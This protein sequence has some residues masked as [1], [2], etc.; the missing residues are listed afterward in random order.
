MYRM[1]AIEY[2]PILNNSEKIRFLPKYIKCI[3]LHNWFMDGHMFIVD[4]HRLGKS[5]AINKTSILDNYL[6]NKISP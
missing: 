5:A 1:D 6:E 3:I 4:T 2:T